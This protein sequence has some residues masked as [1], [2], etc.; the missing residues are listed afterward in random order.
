MKDDGW[1]NAAGD[2]YAHRAYTTGRR[3]MPPPNVI[4]PVPP[5]PPGGLPAHVRKVSTRSSSVP[6]LELVDA[7]SQPL[8]LSP[9]QQ[10]HHQHQHPGKINL[11]EFANVTD[12]IARMKLGSGGG[13]KDS[14]NGPPPPPPPR[15]AKV[16]FRLYELRAVQYFRAVFNSFSRL[17]KID[18]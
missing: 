4:P 2:T 10:P 3:K 13:G 17:T 6:S 14:G 15:L 16:S 12:A 18:I 11:S 7:M 9:F 8:I 5:I 1:N